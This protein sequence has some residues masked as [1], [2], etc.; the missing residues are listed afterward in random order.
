MTE[1]PPIVTP[2]VGIPDVPPGTLLRMRPGEWSHCARVPVGTYLEMTVCRIH[3]NV[4]RQDEAGRWVWVVGH[5]HPSCTWA[6]VEPHPPCLQL[7][8]RL[9]VLIGAVPG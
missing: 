8:V 4:I 3:R 6:H 9:D 5:E 2:T 7:M 1:R